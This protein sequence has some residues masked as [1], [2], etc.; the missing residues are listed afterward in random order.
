MIQYA[1]LML[2][3]DSLLF[4]STSLKFSDGGWLP[5]HSALIVFLLMSDLVFRCE[6]IS[7]LT[8]TAIIC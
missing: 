6:R 8:N 1:V 4:I 3:Y 2:L 7:Q 5:N